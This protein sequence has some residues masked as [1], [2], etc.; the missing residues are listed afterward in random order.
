VIKKEAE[1]VIKC[2]ELMIE[3]KRMWSLKAKVMPVK[4]GATGTISTSLRKYKSNIPGK[5]EFKKPRKSVVLCTIHILREE[6]M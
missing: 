3:I 2:E 6:L 4:T 5:H 1:T